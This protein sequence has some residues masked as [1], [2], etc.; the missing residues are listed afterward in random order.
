MG[1]ASDLLIRMESD[2]TN[3]PAKK[4][5]PFSVD[6]LLATK[7]K[8]QE[9]EN[10]DNNNDKKDPVDLSL[11]IIPKK[12][13]E[14]EEDYEEDEDLDEEDC[15]DEAKVEAH[16]ILSPHA[17]FP[18]GLPGLPALPPVVP[19]SSGFCNPVN[20]WMPQFRSPLNPFLPRKSLDK[21]KPK[22]VPFERA[23]RLDHHLILLHKR[24]TGGV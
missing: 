5:S 16:P 21:L 8:Q 14:I 19:V 17:R 12:E 9:E 4:F 13:E 22:Q 23:L 7:V 3:K 18:L 1:S 15:E 20:P 2:A 24:D 10:S 11:K 6:S